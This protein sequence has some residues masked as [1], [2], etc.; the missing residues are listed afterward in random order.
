MK[1]GQFTVSCPTADLKLSQKTSSVVFEHFKV[2]NSVYTA[3]RTYGFCW[4]FAIELVWRMRAFLYQLNHRGTKTLK[5][6]G[7]LFFFSRTLIMFIEMIDQLWH[8]FVSL[9]PISIK[10]EYKF[11]SQ[12]IISFN[13]AMFDFI[14]MYNLQFDLQFFQQS[15]YES[16]YVWNKIV[17]TM[18]IK[19]CY[20]N[21]LIQMIIDW[22]S[23]HR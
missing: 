20:K 19:S 5:I 6:L 3:K 2:N 8:S 7:I 9:R 23:V 12:R 4:Q 11:A 21:L 14:S 10:Y 1:L 22:Y 16:R 17:E 13:W 15:W 18:F